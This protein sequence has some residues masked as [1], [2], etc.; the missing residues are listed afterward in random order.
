[1]SEP[2]DVKLLDPDP[3]VVVGLIGKV[4][5]ATWP[6]AL[7][8]FTAYFAGLG[9]GP[10]EALDWEIDVPGS[11]HGALTMPG[12]QMQN[13]SWAA[14]HGKLFS[15]N[16]FFFP[17]KHGSRALSEAGFEAVRQR[18]IAAYGSPADEGLDR[19]GNRSAFWEVRESSIELYG[20]VT[21]APALQVGLGRRSVE[22]AYNELIQEGNPRGPE[23]PT[24]HGNR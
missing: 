24:G 4:L 12:I 2:V 5:A 17:G 10:G 18:L 16:F 8:Q 9:C 15:L 19:N 14:L 1:M 20:H 22:S 3:D 23:P 6:E 7:D 13:G 11:T 21:L